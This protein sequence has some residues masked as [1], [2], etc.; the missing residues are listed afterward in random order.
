MQLTK[1]LIAILKQVNVSKNAEKT[2]QRVK[3]DFSS[4]SRADK[5]AITDLTGLKRTSIYRV[6]DTGNASA[7]IVLAMAQVLNVSPFFYTGEEDTK[8]PLE[9]KAMIDFLTKNGGKGVLAALAPGQPEKKTR[10]R[11]KAAAPA[12]AK[13]PTKTAKGK[14]PDKAKKEDTQEDMICFEVA[15]P[16]SDEIRKSIANLP[17]EDA[18]ALLHTLYIRARASSDAKELLEFVKRSLLL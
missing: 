11:K 3:D 4:A 5:A 16:D 10:G 13:T 12:K 17:E 2:K 8:H 15:F 1:E 7:K 18:A 14:A 6:F 9:N